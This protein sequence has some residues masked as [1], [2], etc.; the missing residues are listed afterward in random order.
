MYLIQSKAV[1]TSL[2]IVEDRTARASTY[3]QD[4]NRRKRGYKLEEKEEEIS[5]YRNLYRNF[6]LKGKR[7]W[8]QQDQ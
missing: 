7:N 8:K 4:V 1:E 3:W 5:S 6:S 2:K